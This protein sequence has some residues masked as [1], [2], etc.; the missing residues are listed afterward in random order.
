ML[1]PVVLDFSVVFK[2]EVDAVVAFVD[3]LLVVEVISE[4]L[5]LVFSLVGVVIEVL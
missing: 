5:E 3:I 2:V 4:V 1:V